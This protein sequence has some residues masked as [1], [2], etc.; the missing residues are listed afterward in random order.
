MAKVCRI[1]GKKILGDILKHYEV[2]HF[3]IY[4]AN[5]EIYRNFPVRSW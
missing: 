1:C 3:S 5:R 2:E 4:A